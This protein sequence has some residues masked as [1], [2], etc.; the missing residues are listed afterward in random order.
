MPAENLLGKEG[1]GFNI[2]MDT[3]NGGR[4]GIAAQ[5]RHRGRGVR[6]GLAYS[7]QRKQFDQFIS[8]FQAIQFKL[9]DMYARIE[10]SKLMIYKAAWLKEN[11]MTYAMESAMCK[12]LAS[13]AATY[14]TK[15]AMQILGGYGYI[16]D[17]EVDACTAMPKLPRSTR[18]P[19]RSSESLFQN[20]CLRNFGSP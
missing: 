10:T 15:E 18:G 7:K 1:K 12:M 6:A 16:C 3:L 17:Y 20:C 4:I 2:A 11:K 8:E 9:A 5:R 14:V 13:E 19:M